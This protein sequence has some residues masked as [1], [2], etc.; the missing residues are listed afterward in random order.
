MELKP[1][2]KRQ[3]ALYDWIES[4]VA[5]TRVAPS[6]REIGDEFEISSPNGVIAHLRSMEKKGW[7]KRRKGIARGL[8]LM[9]R[10]T[11]K[12]CGQVLRT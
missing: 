3:Q 1:L 12:C 9:G 2:T 6:I 7:V 10:K 4:Q 8:V 11:C 5:R